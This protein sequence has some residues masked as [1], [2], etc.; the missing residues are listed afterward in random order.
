MEILATLT[1]ARKKNILRQAD[2][3]LEKIAV[4]FRKLKGLKNLFNAIYI[5]SQN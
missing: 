4:R 2:T 1:H 5:M 3:K